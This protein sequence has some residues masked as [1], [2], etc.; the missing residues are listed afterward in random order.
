[1][2][3]KGALL[4]SLSRVCWNCG[5]LRGLEL[6]SR[7]V[8][9]RRGPKGRPAFPYLRRRAVPSFQILTFHRVSSAFDSFFPGLKVEVFARQME[10]LATRYSVVDLASLLSQLDRGDSIPRN[11]VALTFDDGYRD[12][13]EIAFPVLRR[14][15]LPATIFLTT[16]FVNRK[17]ILWNDKVCFALKHSERRDLRMRFGSEER[18]FDLS[19][20]ER[21]L[22]AAREVLRYLFH[23]QHAERQ[24][25]IAQ[26]LVELQVND[27]GHLWDSMLTWDQ[28]RW[29]KKEAIAFGAHTVSHPILS[30]LPRNAAAEEILQSKNVIES[31]LQSE[32]ELFAYPL[33]RTIDFND[34]VKSAVRAAGFRAAVTTIFGTNTG[35]TDRFELRRG[36]PD[37]EGVW[38]FAC[39]Q[40]WYLFSH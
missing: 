27:F 39:K 5:M 34:E 12:N 14:L 38:A 1:M 15:G 31:Q 20:P 36:G 24:S 35:A 29:M 28:I 30:R 16:D 40:C 33:G 23:V 8:Q 6:F 37:D 26:L 11:A 7:E 13:Y 19:T 4:S 22:G 10:Y 3:V 18:Q 25:F 9:L 21:R 2:T 17:D 32:V